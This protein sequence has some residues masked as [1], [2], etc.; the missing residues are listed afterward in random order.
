[1]IRIQGKVDQWPHG[2]PLSDLPSGLQRLMLN[3]GYVFD[4]GEGEQS[5]TVEEHVEPAVTAFDPEEILS[6]PIRSIG[7]AISTL[8]DA[9]ALR[10]LLKAE[11]EGKA[12]VGALEVIE[13]RLEA[14][15]NG[16]D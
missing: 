5:S 6:G 8:D 13:G 12:R 15:T 7:P 3:L 11:S 2:T 4:D 1:M 16:G 9:E 10:S 14:L